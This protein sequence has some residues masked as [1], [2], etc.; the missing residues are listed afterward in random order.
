MRIRLKHL[1]VYFI[2]DIIED[3]LWK[4]NH[5]FPPIQLQVGWQEIQDFQNI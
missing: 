2:E 1:K 5:D 4:P 3:W